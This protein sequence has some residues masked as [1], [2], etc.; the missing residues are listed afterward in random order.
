[1]PTRVRRPRRQPD[2]H[3]TRSRHAHRPVVASRGGP[4]ERRRR[5][6]AGPR[7]GRHDATAPILVAGAEDPGH[8]FHL[9]GRHRVGRGAARS[10]SSATTCSRCVTGPGQPTLTPTPRPTAAPDRFPESDGGANAARGASPGARSLQ[11]SRPGRRCQGRPDGR[12]RLDLRQLLHRESAQ[13]SKLVSFSTV[14]NVYE[15]ICD[16][17]T[18]GLPTASQLPS[19]EVGPT[20]DD[21]VAALGAQVNT[22]MSP[23]VDVSVGGYAGRA[24]HD[25]HLGSLRP[26]LR[27]D[28]ARPMWVDAAG[29]PRRGL[30][31]G[32]RTRSGSSMSRGGGRHRRQ[33]SGRWPRPQ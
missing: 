15:D 16:P 9:Q 3:R 6:P 22:D 13:S 29:E 23:P 33:R 10:R 12:G 30:Q 27:D 11:P 26:L 28:E 4:R 8:E 18:G 19:P 21:L 31:P 2:D 32:I 17:A 25:D 1:M 5:A 24:R 7:R 20:V 14:A